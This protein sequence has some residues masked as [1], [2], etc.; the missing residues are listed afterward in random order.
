MPRA[1]VVSNVLLAAIVLAQAWA[2]YVVY[3]PDEDGGVSIGLRS[4]GRADH[5]AGSSSGSPSEKD[6]DAFERL[7]DSLARIDAR[8]A[9]LE[10]SGS[11]SDAR[12]ATIVRPAIPAAVADQRLRSMLKSNVMTG[13]DVAVF[14]A[15][16]AGLPKEERFALSTALARAINENRIRLRP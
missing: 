13:D 3:V 15:R 11:L 14:Q 12:A 16:L 9:V 2:L 1:L 8:L 10:G 6:A 4:A 7:A 5:A